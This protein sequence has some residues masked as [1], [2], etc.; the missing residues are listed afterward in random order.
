MLSIILKPFLSKTGQKI[1]IPELRPDTALSLSVIESGCLFVLTNDKTA[2][3]IKTIE[4]EI[5]SLIESNRISLDFELIMRPEFPSL[6]AYII[7]DT[8]SNDPLRFEY[9]FN[10]ES[11]EEIG[12]LEKLRYQEYLDILFYGSRIEHIKRTAIT[13]D[14]KTELASLLIQ[15]RE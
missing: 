1:E 4:T 13:N 10:I 5:A 3:I 12:L 14:K 6:A 8:D 11:E 9:F 15:A 2:L 7:I